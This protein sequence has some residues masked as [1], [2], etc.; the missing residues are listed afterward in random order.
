MEEPLYGFVVEVTVSENQTCQISPN[1][2]NDSMPQCQLLGQDSFNE[3]NIPSGMPKD[4]LYKSYDCLY[5]SWIH[6]SD[7]FDF[8]RQGN[9]GLSA[10]R[11]QCRFT[12]AWNMYIYLSFT[13]FKQRNYSNISLAIILLHKP[14]QKIKA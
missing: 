3:N 8:D 4:L 13:Y 9:T 10:S 14:F 6:I 2:E 5:I 11:P 12:A 7:D 1:S